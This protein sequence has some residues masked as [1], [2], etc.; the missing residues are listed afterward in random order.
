M[1][2]QCSLLDSG[3]PT[4]PLAVGPVERVDLGRGAWLDHCPAWLPGSDSWFDDLR[5]DL[6]WSAHSRPMYERI[7]DVPRLICAFDGRDDPRIPL[8]VST[9]ADVL[10]NAY[11]PIERISANWYRDGRDSVAFHPDKVPFPGDSLV[12]IVAVG[13]RRPFLLR[14]LGGGPSRRFDIGRGDLLV[15]GGTCQAFFEHA[16]PKIARPAARMSLMFR[17]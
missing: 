8:P 14:P 6:P 13:E 7:V 3:R 5:R 17:A 9:I 10:G 15:M 11:R 1:F 12:A 2:Y 16:V 4:V